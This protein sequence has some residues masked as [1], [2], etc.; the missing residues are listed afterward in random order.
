MNLKKPERVGLQN[1]SGW[2]PGCGHG[3]VTRLIAEAAEEL[4]ISLS[5][6][7]Y[8]IRALKKEG[9]IQFRGSGGKG[10]WEI[11]E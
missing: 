5:G 7:N 6:V 8:R 1:Q 11:L 3:V 10:V 9:R 2:C 4:G